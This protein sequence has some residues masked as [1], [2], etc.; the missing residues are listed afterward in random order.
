[1]STPAGIYLKR[2]EWALFLIPSAT[3]LVY[4]Y[5]TLSFVFLT[6]YPGILFTARE[7]GWF[8]NDSAQ[9]TISV[10]DMLARI[11]ELTISDYQINRLEAPFAGLEAGDEIEVQKLGE[12]NPIILQIQEPTLN[13]RLKRGLA[14]IGFFPFWIAG[15]AIL[16]FLRPQDKRWA[17]LLT[18]M[19]LI[20]IW[21]TVGA[22]SS[23]R[24]AG[25]RLFLGM[26]FWLM[27]P[28][29]I[30]LHLVIPTEISSRLIKGTI[31][32]IYL[33][34]AVCIVLELSQLMPPN[35]PFFGALIGVVGSIAILGY[36]LVTSPKKS[37]AQLSTRLMFAGILIAF[38]PGILYELLPM[39]LNISPATTLGLSISLLAI[40]ILPFFYVYAVYKRQLGALE[41]RTNRLIAVYSFALLYPPLFLL[42]ILYGNNWLESAGDRTIYL[43]VVSTVFVVTT[44]ALLN[45]FKR[46]IN[47]LAYGTKHDPEELIRIFANQV[48]SALDR[49]NLI[50]LI[51][52]DILPSLLIRQS[53][54]ILL[55]GQDILG[56]IY[57]QEVEGRELGSI[58]KNLRALLQS[59]NV[60]QPPKSETYDPRDWIRLAILLKVRHEVRGLWLFGK[61]DPDDYYPQADIELLT[62]LANQ[63]TPVIENIQLYEALQLHAQGLAV[64]VADRTA[65]L[66]SAKDRTQAILDSAG[67]GIFFTDPTGIILYANPKMNQLTGYTTEELLGTH[68]KKLKLDTSSRE[69]S[70]QLLLAIEKGEKWTGDLIL[71]RKD[72]STY[73]ASMTIAPLNSGN[74]KI[75]GF[76]GVQSDISK[77]KEIDRLKSEIIANVSHELR[78]P[79]TNISMYIQL[80][81]MG[82]PERQAQYYKVLDHETERLARLIEDLLELSKLDSGEVTMHMVPTDLCRIIRDVVI[83][84]E[85]KAESKAIKLI[86]AEETNDIPPVLVDPIQISQVFNNIVTNAI[87]Y[88]APQN[89]IVVHFGQDNGSHNAFVWTSISD[90]GPGIAPDEIPHLF[91]RFYRGQAGQ[92]SEVPGTGLGLAISQE[93]VSRHHGKIEVASEVGVGTTFTIWLPA[94]NG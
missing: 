32:F 11:G 62:T 89:E 81:K 83:S 42:F 60:Y 2:K 31:A 71:V 94:A 88:I 17:L 16:L 59:S 48:P 63:I 54:M 43:L 19:Y 74:E 68:L 58:R 18:F 92:A 93:I 78:T 34:A 79:L 64:Q 45:Y 14:T 46:F 44:P 55:Q 5:Y 21:L 86:V 49:T 24:I 28:V 37:A 30:H 1:M 69:A 35:T 67:E 87:N 90:N 53:C 38:V 15:T 77:F 27:A 36:R 51:E 84:H 52:G 66:Q 3:L 23:W 13:D 40:P 50:R 20:A 91:E 33:F 65:E 22:V 85:A 25:S 29:F 8:I 61:R 9:P 12:S 82:N 10:G 26:A 47:R 6:P 72:G 4:I 39:L 76:V 75:E 70:D 80:L 73:D 57:A 7:N 41:F 56:H